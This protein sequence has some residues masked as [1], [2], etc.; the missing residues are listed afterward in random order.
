[1]HSCP[2]VPEGPPT[3]VVAEAVDTR[4]ILLSWQPP[5]PD[6]RNGIIG[7]YRI[8]YSPVADSTSTRIITT[9]DTQRLI[10]MGITPD[11]SFSFT[12]AARTAVGG[13]GPESLPIIQTSY[14]N[15]PPSPQERPQTSNEADITM[16]TIP[17]NL[18]SI[19]TSL[20]RS[21]CELTRAVRA[22]QMRQ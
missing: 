11:T 17:F 7:S 15:P 16:T 19:N 1:M 12:V 13:F 21:A 3:N 2:T 10:T 22:V 14:S 4:S 5:D 18:P 6:L 8:T 20:F 9:G